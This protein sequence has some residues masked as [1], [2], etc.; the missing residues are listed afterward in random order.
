M[1][2]KALLKDY[3]NQQHMMQLATVHDGQPWVCTVYFVADEDFNLYWASLPT[4]RHSL[5]ITNDSHAAVAIAVKH[6]KG[7]PVVGIQMSGTAEQLQPSI[8]H[9]AIVKSYATRFNRDDQW[10][11]DFTEG[12]TEHRLYKFT[13]AS[14]FLFDE[15][16]FP[17]GS[18]QQIR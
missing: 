6:V 10:I 9:Q 16:Y 3:L 13:P 5:E 8:N 18:R 4:R 15:V 11:E 17:G 2:P 14:I 7:E 12:N 1:D